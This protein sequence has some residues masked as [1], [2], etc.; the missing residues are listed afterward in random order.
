MQIRGRLCLSIDKY[1]HQKKGNSIELSVHKKAKMSKTL[2]FFDTYCKH[3]FY[4]PSTHANINGA[5]M[6]ASLSTINFGV[7][8]SNLPQVIFSLGTAPL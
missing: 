6:V 8:I 5:T 4:K 7:R 2:R 1:N 3:K